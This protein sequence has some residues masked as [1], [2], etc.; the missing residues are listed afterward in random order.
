MRTS[1]PSKVL[2]IA[3]YGIG[4]LIL[5]YPVLK[6]LK[7]RGIAF[8]I[9]SFLK[10]VDIM[11]EHWEE[12]RCL[13][14]KRFFVPSKPGDA[15]KALCAIRRERYSCSVLSFPSAKWHYNAFSFACGARLRSV[16][17]YPDNSVST[18]SFLNQARIPVEIG[19][20]DALQ[21]ARIAQGAGLSLPLECIQKFPVK[22]GPV[23]VLGIHPGCKAS[24]SYKRWDLSRWKDLLERLP[25]LYPHLEIRLYLGPDEPEERALLAG[26]PGL[27][28]RDSLPLK[29]LHQ[30][31]GQCGL[32]LSNDSGLMHIASFMGA[33]SL[34][35]AGPSDVRRTGP[36]GEYAHILS[37]DCPLKP[38]SHTYHRSSHHFHCE[39]GRQC[40]AG[41]SVDQVLAAVAKALL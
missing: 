39:L 13:Y 21:N 20:H 32:F 10:S 15:L 23:R 8:D 22:P 28:V 11:L 18:L 36:F 24:D 16:A 17:L 3:P 7:E 38:C 25:V 37:A 9:V 1:S 6:A 12:F 4:N 31:I 35:I 14:G 40:L 27:V 2:V 29:T 19:L 30:D 26:L 41:V 34:V 5:L 33:R